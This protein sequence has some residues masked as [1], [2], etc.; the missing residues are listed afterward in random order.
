MVELLEEMGD[1]FNKRSMDY[2]AVHLVH[3][4]DIMHRVIYMRGFLL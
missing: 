1:F 4:C 3:V 2:N